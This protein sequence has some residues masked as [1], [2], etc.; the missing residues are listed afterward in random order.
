MDM[1]IDIHEKDGWSTSA[2]IQSVSSWIYNRFQQ[3]MYLHQKQRH[4]ARNRQKRTVKRRNPEQ[5]TITAFHIFCAKVQNEKQMNLRWLLLGNLWGNVLKKIQGLHYPGTDSTPKEY[6][7]YA[8]VVHLIN[9]VQVLLDGG[10][11]S[12]WEFL[13]IKKSLWKIVSISMRNDD[14]RVWEKAK[15]LLGWVL[16]WFTKS[17]DDIDKF[18]RYIE[19]NDWTSHHTWE[20]DAPEETEDQYYSWLTP[21]ETEEYEDMYNAWV[22][23]V[24]ARERNLAEWESEWYEQ[25]LNLDVREEYSDVEAHFYQEQKL[26]REKDNEYSDQVYEYTEKAREVA[27]LYYDFQNEYQS[28]Y[29]YPSEWWWKIMDDE[30]YHLT[31]RIWEIEVRNIYN[32]SYTT[33][34][35]MRE[36]DRWF[37]WLINE[38][39]CPLWA[40]IR[41]IGKEPKEVREL[42]IKKY[43]SVFSL[44]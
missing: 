36:I 23:K 1:Y 14:S 41:E 34:E 17:L 30:F 44:G 43:L 9:D 22:A 24:E 26:R 33:Y 20:K 13:K 15:E 29:W 37:L 16:D 2:K 38:S 35:I 27:S 4:Y 3:M 39:I 5:Y 42:F 21:T 18:A 10:V 31:L 28:I 6:A 7:K 32:Q 11:Q 19:K 25:P 40:W 8:Q 12:F